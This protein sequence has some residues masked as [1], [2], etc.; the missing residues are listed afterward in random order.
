MC[1]CRETRAPIADSTVNSRSADHADNRVLDAP[2]GR[3]R[4]ELDIPLKCG[5]LCGRVDA[6][7]LPRDPGAPPRRAEEERNVRHRRRGHV[8]LPGRERPA[9]LGEIAGPSR[10]L[11]GAMSE[12]NEIELIFEPLD[13]GGFHV[14]VPDFPGLHTQGD[15]LD[16]ATKNAEEALALYVEGVR[17]DGGSLDSGVI[18]RKLPL[19]A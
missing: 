2:R 18:R 16:E 3:P 1:P 6:P 14:Y 15:D 10:T 4:W 5:D 8:A 19:P 7:L 11:D 13:E 17:E 9:N 12:A